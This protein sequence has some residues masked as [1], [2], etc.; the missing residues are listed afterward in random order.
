MIIFN[1]E[2]SDVLGYKTLLVRA[3]IGANNQDGKRIEGE[4]NEPFEIIG[5][6]QAAK[7]SEVVTTPSSIR[8]LIKFKLYT[9]AV[10]VP[11]DMPNFNQVFCE[12]ENAWLNVYKT[13][14]FDFGIAHNKYFLFTVED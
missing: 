5:G 7:D 9:S 2:R 14:P 1:I 3:Q 10:L 4:F 13:S 11:F 6:L 8:N 12:S